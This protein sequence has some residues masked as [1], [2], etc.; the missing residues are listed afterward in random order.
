VNP[1]LKRFA[2]LPF[3]K[4][5]EEV[6]KYL[7][8]RLKGQ[9]GDTITVTAKKFFQWYYGERNYRSNLKVSTYADATVFWEALKAVLPLLGLKMHVVYNPT[10]RSMIVRLVLSEKLS[11][12]LEAV[13]VVATR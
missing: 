9:K 5:K 10:G 8:W 11:S 6:Y 1:V 3:E 2:S 13:K 7:C 12:K 4:A